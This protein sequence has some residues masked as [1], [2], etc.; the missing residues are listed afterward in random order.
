MPTS[1]P[2][3]KYAVTPFKMSFSIRLHPHV[4]GAFSN[5]IYQIKVILI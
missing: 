5:C 4:L 3:L 2:G 1:S